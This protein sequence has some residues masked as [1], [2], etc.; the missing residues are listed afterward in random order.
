MTIDAN[1]A[2]AHLTKEQALELLDDA[3]EIRSE[4]WRYGRTATFLVRINELPYLITIDIHHEE[5]WQI[6]DDVLARRAKEVTTTTWVV[7]EGAA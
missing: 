6:Y 2:N 7:D 1:P 3:K 5:G 4:P